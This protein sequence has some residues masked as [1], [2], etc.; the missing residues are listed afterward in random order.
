M[1]L[2]YDKSFGVKKSTSKTGVINGNSG[3]TVPHKSQ[4]LTV[5]SL[6]GKGLPCKV[7]SLILAMSI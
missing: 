7:S 6:G 5:S 1:T 3:K 4:K 2:F